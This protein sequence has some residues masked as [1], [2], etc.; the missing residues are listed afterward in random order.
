MRDN[1]LPD[2]DVLVVGGGLAGIVAA[3]AARSAG[4][5]VMVVGR[6]GGGTA[7][8]SGAV[9]LADDLVDTTPG[10]HIA[11]LDRGPRLGDAIARL[12]AR[13]PRHP[14]ARARGDLTRAV[15]DA[16]GAVSAAAPTLDFVRRADGH[17]HVIATAFG[18]VKRAALVPASQHLDLLELGADAVVGIVDWHDLAGFGAAPVAALLTHLA[19]LGPSAARP[20]FVPVAVPRVAAAVFRDAREMARALDD[21]DARSRALATLRRAVGAMATPPTHLLTPAVLGTHPLGAAELAD[22]DGAVGRPL[23][24][25]VATP[26]SVPAARLFQALRAQAACDDIALV[27]GVVSAPVIEGGT[28]RRVTVT[29]PGG[30]RSVQAAALVLATGRF[31]AGGLVRD[32]VAREA[33]FGL[34]VV[35]DGRVVGD[36]FIGDLVGEHVDADHAI[37]RAGLAVDERWRPLDATGRPVAGNVFAAGHIIG[38]WDPTRDGGAL[39]VAAWTARHAGTQAAEVTR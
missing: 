35:A 10:P 13:R 22:I 9:D 36:A 5:R 27:D 21:D 31:F 23:R 39:G 4:R 37:F 14:L 24:E 30:A 11:A 15:D 19:R 28:L 29:D 25:L 38:G 33:L 26:P 17:N 12:G 34:P 1:A 16:L 32:Q 8:W 2:V 18:T 6:A 7:S 20:T 3:R